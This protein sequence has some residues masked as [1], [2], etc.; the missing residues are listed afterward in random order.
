MGTSKIG[1]IIDSMEP[2]KAAAEL[3]RMIKKLFPL[4]GEEARLSFIM[5]LVGDSGEDKLASMVH[6]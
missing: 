5:N 1:E 4:L 2:E 3:A 6:L